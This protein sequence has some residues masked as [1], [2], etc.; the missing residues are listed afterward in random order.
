MNRRGQLA[1][2]AVDK[3]RGDGGEFG[4]HALGEEGREHTREHIARAAGGEG[5]RTGGIEIYLS[6]RTDDGGE[7]SFQDDDHMALAGNLDGL[8]QAGVGRRLPSEQAVELA[9]VGSE[10]AHHRDMVEHRWTYR[11]AVEGVGIEHKR[12]RVGVCDFKEGVE[13]VDGDVGR[14]Y[15]GTDCHSLVVARELYVGDGNIAGV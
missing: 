14:A 12:A 2:E 8:E 3:R 10:D 4:T 1:G 11:H 9:G 6:V 13:G 15:A 7:T 5:G